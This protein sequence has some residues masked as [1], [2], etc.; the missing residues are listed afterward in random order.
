MVYRAHLVRR[1]ELDVQRHRFVRKILQ[2]IIRDEPYEYFDEMS[3]LFLSMKKAWSYEDTPVVCPVNSGARLKMS[4]Y[5]CLSN[6]LPTPFL[7]Y[8][9]QSTNG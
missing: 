5:C 2:F 8:K 7:D 3:L 1:N 9:Y 6:V 4:V